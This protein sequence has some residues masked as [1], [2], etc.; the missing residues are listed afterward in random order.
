MSEDEI[1]R[2]ICK[3]GRAMQVAVR[4]LYDAV[5]QHMLRF[6]VY[7]GMS[8][9]ESEDILQETFIKVVRNASSYR[10]DGAARAWIW[11]VAR[12]CLAD[13][14][15]AAGRRSESVADVDDEQWESII[16][17]TAAPPDCPPG[18]T[19]DECVSKGLEAFAAQ[20]PERAYALTLQM[21]GCSIQEIAERVGRTVGATKEY[22]SQCKKKI[23]PFLA[24][25][26]ELLTS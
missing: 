6:F 5:G 20:M 23:Q 15:R 11:Q 16:E 1:L 4:H 25:C 9:A 10:G 2:E 18:E 26:A 7:N 21:D 17:S 8:G 22:L 14:Q 24:H 12:N 13:H 19:A 3:G